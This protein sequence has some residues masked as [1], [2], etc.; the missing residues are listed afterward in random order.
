[1]TCSI[2]EQIGAMVAH[3]ENDLAEDPDDLEAMRKLAL[4]S[5]IYR[6]FA[7]GGLEGFRQGYDRGYEAVEEDLRRAGT[8]PAPEPQRT[9]TAHVNA[10]L[11]SPDPTR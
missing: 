7:M 10:E 1:M 11:L 2:G 9:N 3:L 4:T 8:C 5:E 6:N